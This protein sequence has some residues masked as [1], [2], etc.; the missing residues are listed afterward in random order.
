[1]LEDTNLLM[2]SSDV[3]TTK[4]NSTFLFVLGPDEE[5]GG[6]GVDEVGGAEEARSVAV[7]ARLPRRFPQKGAIPQAGGG[8]S[9]LW[10]EQDVDFWM[11]G[12]RSRQQPPPAP[13]GSG[14]AGKR[15]AAKHARFS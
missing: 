8:I 1:M 10:P 5:D 14:S 13:S 6:G 11:E 12:S 3:T 7:C 9:L 4:K 2:N 15:H